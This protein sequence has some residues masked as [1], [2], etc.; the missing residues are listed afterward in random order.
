MALTLTALGL[1]SGLISGTACNTSANDIKSNTFFGTWVGLL[2]TEV[3]NKEAMLL[4]INENGSYYADI[5]KRDSSD[6]HAFSHIYGKWTANGN[7][8]CLEPPY[9]T[10]YL[11]NGAEKNDIENIVLEHDN[12]TERLEGEAALLHR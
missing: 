5:T 1:S 4:V 9:M 8:V 3:F 2:D 11:P 10:L 12:I 6:K 7:S